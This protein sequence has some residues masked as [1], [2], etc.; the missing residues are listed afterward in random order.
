M[1]DPNF[2]YQHLQALAR[3][4]AAPWTLIQSLPISYSYSCK[5]GAVILCDRASTDQLRGVCSAPI[6]S[7][8]KCVLHDSRSRQQYAEKQYVDATSSKPHFA[9]L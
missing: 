2:V 1:G 4:I 7:T 5:E 6:E 9:V 8:G 3:A